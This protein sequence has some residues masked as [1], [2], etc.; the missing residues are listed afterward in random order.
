MNVEKINDIFD[1]IKGRNGNRTKNN[2]RT[3][4]TLP[5]DKRSQ[6]KHK[7]YAQIAAE[8]GTSL[9]LNLSLSANTMNLV[10]LQAADKPQPTVM[11]EAKAKTYEPCAATSWSAFPAGSTVPNLKGWERDKRETVK[12]R[13]KRGCGGGEVKLTHT[14]TIAVTRA[15]IGQHNIVI[16]GGRGPIEARG[17]ILKISCL[18]RSHRSTL[19]CP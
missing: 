15:L 4:H 11:Y 9:C 8:I 7:R 17:H 1:E 2:D 18:S 16:T 10:D 6:K 19:G 5:E 12:S 3:L 14:A 13:H